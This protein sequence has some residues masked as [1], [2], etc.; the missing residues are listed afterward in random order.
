MCQLDLQCTQVLVKILGLQRKLLIQLDRLKDIAR[1]DLLGPR[2][3]DDIVALREEPRQRNLASGR[4]V[5]FPNLLEPV[6]KHQD[7][8]KV[9]VAIFWKDLA[10]I[11]FGEVGGGFLKQRPV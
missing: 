11:T 5:S 10:E 2:D 1:T 9:L 6:R 8:G 4:A 7:V 3:R